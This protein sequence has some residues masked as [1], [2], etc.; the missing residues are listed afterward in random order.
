MPCHKS[1]CHARRFPTQAASLLICFRNSSMPTVQ[2]T[3][4]LST[5]APSAAPHP[6]PLPVRVPG[7]GRGDETALPPRYRVMRT[8]APSLPATQPAPRFCRAGRTRPTP[9]PLVLAVVDQVVDHGRVGERRGVAEVGEIVLGDLAQDAAHDLAG[10]GLRQA[11]RELDE[12]GRGDRADDPC[13][14]WRP[15]PSSGRRRR[16]RR[17]S[18]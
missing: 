10:A 8:P 4:L 12:V 13:G 18:G 6:N 14:P 17:P 7:T 15:A 11:R 2:W 3:W 16:S 5:T 9:L 1:A